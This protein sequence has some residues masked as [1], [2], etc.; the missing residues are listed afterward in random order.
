M[1]TY[2]PIHLDRSTFDTPPSLYRDLEHHTRFQRVLRFQEY[3]NFAEPQDILEEF[4]R[5]SKMS[6]DIGFEDPLSLYDYDNMVLL[7]DDRFG[8]HQTEFQPG[9]DITKLYVNIPCIEGNYHCGV[10]CRLI[11]HLLGVGCNKCARDYGI[12]SLYPLE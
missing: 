11:D 1:N 9:M 8:R 12:S 6:C 3:V 4:I 7:I 2:Q 10:N 5:L